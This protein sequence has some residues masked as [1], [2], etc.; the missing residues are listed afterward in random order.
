MWLRD[1]NLNKFLDIQQFPVPGWWGLPPAALSDALYILPATLDMFLK[2]SHQYLLWFYEEMFKWIVLSKALSDLQLSRVTL[3]DFGQ[4]TLVSRNI[5]YQRH[6]CLMRS[7]GDMSSDGRT[8]RRTD[9]HNGDT[10]LH[11][12]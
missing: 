4:Q 12:I 3:R 5:C 6:Q 10:M 2:I 7:L 9:G 8:E 1:G 11:L